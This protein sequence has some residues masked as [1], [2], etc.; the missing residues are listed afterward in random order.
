MCGSI[1]GYV[2]MLNLVK[3]I[4]N[5]PPAYLEWARVAFNH[6]FLD[7]PA[8]WAVLMAACHAE[9]TVVCLNNT[10]PKRTDL[11]MTL[12]STVSAKSK[13]Y[14]FSSLKK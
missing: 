6:S 2:F 11:E 12:V 14:K 1:D 8:A 3:T 5:E 13:L 4:P 9:N 10:Q 7:N